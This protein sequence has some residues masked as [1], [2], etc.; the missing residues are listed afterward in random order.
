MN[1]S[2]VR[3]KV[4]NK[5]NVKNAANVAI[6]KGATANMGSI[7]MNKSSV[8]GKVI[9]KSN[10]KNAANVAIGKGS[11]ANMGSVVME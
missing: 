7:T 6:G 1:K 3:G 2:S 11:E 10:V 5:S 9:N 4:I 8:K